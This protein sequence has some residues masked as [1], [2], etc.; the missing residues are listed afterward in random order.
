MIYFDNNATTPVL[1]EVR[2]AMAPFLDGDF[3]NPNSVYQPATKV[4]AVIERCRGEVARLIGARPS[5]IIFTGSGSESNNH[6]IVGVVLRNLG[7]Q[8][9]LV[10]SPIEHSSVKAAAEWACRTFGLE[11]RVAPFRVKNGSV[12]LEPYA[13]V[14]DEHTLLVSVMAA[15]NETGVCLP[16][17]EI[18]GLARRAGAVMH[19]DAIQAGGKLPIDVREW[20]VDL[21]SL[22]AHKFHGPKGVGVLYTRKGVA[23]E[24]LIHGGGQ[25]NGH[26]AGTENVAYIVGLTKALSLAYEQGMEKV[27]ALRDHFETSIKARLGEQVKINF[28]DL[29]RTPNACSVCFPGQDANLLIIKLDR[30]GI[31]VSTGSACNSGAL[32]ASKGLMAAGLSEADASST[33]RVSFSK[34][35]TVDEV[36]QVLDALEETVVGKARRVLV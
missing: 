15:N 2:E 32:T 22:S 10:I 34:L 18:A 24:T 20:G 35:N 12:D 6:A 11:L 36:E 17:R 9:N 30:M 26:R 13:D 14:I 7:R 23:L 16:V 5:E 28:G 3:A 8:G 21:L 29:P 25:E 33:V 19:C 4:R 31:C 27:R 1:P